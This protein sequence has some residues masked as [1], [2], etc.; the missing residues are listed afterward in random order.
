[1]SL[2]H[3]MPGDHTPP[4]VPM[5]RLAA[6]VMAFRPTARDYVIVFM[7]GPAGRSVSVKL[8][9]TSQG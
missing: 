9:S 2:W 8:T 6:I 4:A 1:M 5:L 3:G 7:P